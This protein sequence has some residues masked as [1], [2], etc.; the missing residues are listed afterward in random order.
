MKSV[1][2]AIVLT[3]GKKAGI[4]NRV[5]VR[6]AESLLHPGENVI[7]AVIANI[8]TKRNNFP[9]VVLITT[10]NVMAVCGLPGI[11]RCITLPVE[12]L[13]HCEEISSAIQYKALFS[14]RKNMFAMTTGPDLGDRFTTH[15]AQLNRENEEIKLQKKAAA[16]FNS[17]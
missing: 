16:I 15:I 7:A 5:S 4:I 12:E 9:G 2:E 13:L 6:Y 11:K 8:K 10:Q 3:Q 14:T 17:K 1:S